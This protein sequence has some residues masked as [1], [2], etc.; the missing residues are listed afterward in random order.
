MKKTRKEIPELIKRRVQLSRIFSSSNQTEKRRWGRVFFA[1]FDNTEAKLAS[2]SE[3]LKY[4]Q[5]KLNRNS[6]L[7]RGIENNSVECMFCFIDEVT[8]INQVASVF[9]LIKKYNPLFTYGIVRQFKDG[10]GVYDIF[11]FSKFSYLEHHNRVK[12]PS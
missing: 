1:G 8:N 4:K 7:W 6:I 5:E 10:M 12:A 2:L 3:A 11:R 9:R